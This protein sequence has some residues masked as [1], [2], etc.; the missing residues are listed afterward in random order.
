MREISCLAFLLNQY[1][2][3]GPSEVRV[4]GTKQGP[5]RDQAAIQAGYKYNTSRRQAKS[6]A[7][8]A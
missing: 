2:C 4:K 6:G 8:V 3:K 1:G 5:S 7:R